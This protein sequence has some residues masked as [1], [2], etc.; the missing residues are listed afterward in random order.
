MTTAEQTCEVTGDVVLE[1]VLSELSSTVTHFP[2]SQT[3]HLL[4]TSTI[5]HSGW[6]KGHMSVV[7]AVEYR[8]AVKVTDNLCSEVHKGMGQ[9][10]DR[11]V[12]NSVRWIQSFTGH[13]RCETV[14]IQCDALKLGN[15]C[16]QGSSG[17]GQ[18]DWHAYS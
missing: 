3:Q 8:R 12:M 9:I 10:S 18:Q 15:V 6:N 5:V 2:A 11:A 4:V 1:Q 14:S 17:R 16:G 7:K 13:I